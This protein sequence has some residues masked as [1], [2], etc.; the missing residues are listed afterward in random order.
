MDI[1]GPTSVTAVGSANFASGPVA[2]QEI[3]ALFGPGITSQT[4][5]IRITDSAGNNQPARIFSA[6]SGQA[7]ILIPAGLATGSAKI[8]IPQ[9]ASG[10][11]TIASVAPG[12]Y[13]ANADGAGVA[14]ANAFTI[15]AANLTTPQNVFACNPPAAR[16]CL[17][18]PLSQ[19]ASTDTL[20]VALYGT[21]IRAAASV[22]CFVAG[23]S[24]PVLYAGPVA[25][26]PGLDQVNISI[27]KSL[28][29]LGDV[30]VYVIADG[31]VSNVVGLTLQ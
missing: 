12:L 26:D 30:R 4:T 2:P 27:P 10:A 15:S 18:A 14:A 24:V 23:Q 1:S 13:S 3:V 25:S 8:A 17:G 29:G 11:V 31:V 21:G 22:Q 7:N 20:Y 9:G 28:A 6:V 16:S 5:S 19:G